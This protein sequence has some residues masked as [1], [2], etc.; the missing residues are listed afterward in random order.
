MPT[1]RKRPRIPTVGTRG[2][3]LVRLNPRVRHTLRRQAQRR[4]QRLEGPNVRAARQERQPV[5]RAYRQTVSGAKQAIGLSE[6]EL[7]AQV[8]ALKSSGLKG[9]ALRQTRHEL[10][11]RSA[12]LA[13][14]LPFL[15]SQARTE[16]Q[17]GLAAAQQD[18][19]A[20]KAQRAQQT[21]QIY[22]SLLGTTLTQAR[23]SIKARQ[24]AKS[25]PSSKD[26][27]YKAALGQARL[28]FDAAPRATWHGLDKGQWANFVKAVLAGEGVSDPS[29]AR[30][31]ATQVAYKRL[32]DLYGP[33][34]KDFFM[35]W[36][37]ALPPAPKPK[38][39]G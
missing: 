18:V 36:L 19:I 22:N 5:R 26:N 37:R 32:N 21:G 28:Q 38:P 25:S 27:Q 1:P 24:T 14:S 13:S 29:V 4:A 3:N 11:A 9:R 6:K 10:T 34:S 17:S 12:D 2:A 23:S 20:A 30:R 35:R 33:I 8:K 15:T 31:A 16:R 7:A 39:G